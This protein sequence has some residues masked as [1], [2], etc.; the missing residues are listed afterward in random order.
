MNISLT[1]T[2]E[3]SCDTTI[4]AQA[5]E[6]PTPPDVA[7]QP[8]TE[9]KTVTTTAGDGSGSA[10]FGVDLSMASESQRSQQWAG[11]SVM[12]FD[13]VVENT[14]QTNETIA[15]S[16]SEADGNGCVGNVDD[17][18][19]DLSEETVAL[20]QEETETVT[21]SVEVPEG[22]EAS[23]YC[24]EITGT[25]TNDPSQEA[26]DVE[27]F[28]LTVPELHECSMALSKSSMTVD[29]GEESELTATLENT[30]NSDWSV[31]MAKTGSRAGWVSFDGSSSGLLPYDN[32]DG[33]RTFDLIV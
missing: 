21:V 11:E 5:A 22:Q 6:A 17:L 27:D 26:S 2:A 20:D 7:G 9:T 28:D 14:G 16:L 30:G 33:S 10:I 13:V 4:T 3:G 8:A 19:V 23:K 15:L 1:Q 18:S 24:W 25:V 29:P 31:T 12:E 32:G